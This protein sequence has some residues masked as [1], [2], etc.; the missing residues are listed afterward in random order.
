MG[1]VLAGGEGESAD[2]ICWTGPELVGNLFDLICDIFW[3]LWFW[4]RN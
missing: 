3:I 4:F 1:G 2:M